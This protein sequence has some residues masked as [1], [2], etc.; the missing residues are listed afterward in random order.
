MK[1]KIVIT[2]GHLTPA[3]AVIEE[4]MRR[5]NWEIFFF[6][7]RYASEEEKTPSMEF[8]IITEKGLWFIPIDAGRV[9]RK[10][11]LRTVPSLIKIPLGFFQSLW[12]LGKIRPRVIL[13]FGGYL[14]VPV[15]LAGWFLR[16]PAVTHEQASVRGLANKV[17]SLFV[18]KTAVSWP[19]TVG[20]F[21]KNKTVLT[22]N[23]IRQAILQI[24]EEIWRVLK[25]PKQLP[26]IFVTGGN[27]GSHLINRTVEEILPELIA[28]ANIFHQSGHLQARG[29]FER[30]EERRGELSEKFQGRYHVK[31]YLNN[32]E[33]GTLLNRADLIIGRAGANILTEVAALGK[34]TLF[35][36]F[37]WLHQDEQTK[38]AQ[39]LAAVGLAEILPQEKL[40]SH[41]LLQL[42]EKM[43]ANL[44]QYRKNALKGKKLV[45]LDA[46]ERIVDLV[47][48]QAR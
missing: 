9:Q 18:R 6:G 45:K 22:G 38:N 21:P 40:S 29:D 26:L 36:P 13:S 31:K 7:R 43:L 41:A 19:Q 11:T 33:M 27:Q 17:N 32:E 28:K 14:S 46:A 12:H 5:G 20:Q 35:I 44:N 1:R 4:L 42:V 15:I 8:E 37:P 48:E 3:L 34:P 2:G 23:P 10:F 39:I 30:L 24:D 25:F 47:E 16:I